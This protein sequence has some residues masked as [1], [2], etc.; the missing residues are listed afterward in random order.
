M[1]P[2]VKSVVFLRAVEALCLE[3]RAKW[4]PQKI[5]HDIC[6]MFKHQIMSNNL[7]YKRRGFVKN[8]SGGG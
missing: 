4:R 5:R 2:H 8:Q 6:T 3:K 7:I 1:G